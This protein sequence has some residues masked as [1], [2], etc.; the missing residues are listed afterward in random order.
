VADAVTCAIGAS[1]IL[2]HLQDE[3]GGNLVLDWLERGAAISVLNVQKLASK[4]AEAGVERD[5]VE[6]T[7]ADLSL[8]VRQITL[9]L[10]L[11]AGFM[12]PDTG[13]RGL[14]HGDR[15]CLALARGIGVPAVTADR[16]WADVAD[17]LGVEVVLVR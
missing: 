4:L 5:A 9:N 12:R 13:R 16:P 8:E 3:A 15:A 2:A 17:A 10:A 7:L 14:S 11:D 1:T 6:V